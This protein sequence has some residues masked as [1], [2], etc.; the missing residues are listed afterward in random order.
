[1]C[2]CTPHD[3]KCTPSQ[4]KSQFLGQ[5]LLRGLDFEIDLDSLWGRRLKKVVNFFAKKC[6]PRQNPG[7][8]YA[9]E[10]FFFRRTLYTICVAL[11]RRPISPSLVDDTKATAREQGESLNVHVAFLS[12]LK[13]KFAMKLKQNSYFRSVCDQGGKCRFLPLG[14]E[15][16]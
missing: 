7:Y 2:K 1:M 8:A 4:S 12:V 10:L 9:C 14:A 15:L 16:N 5:F 6:T 11:S 3:T 13:S